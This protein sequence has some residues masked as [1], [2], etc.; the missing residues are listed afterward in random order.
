MMLMVRVKST[1]TAHIQLLKND[2]QFASGVFDLVMKL[3]Y[4]A[5]TP[6]NGIV[7]T[8]VG[9]IHDCMHSCVFVRRAKVFDDLG[10]VADSKELMG[11]EE[12][13]VA[14]VREIRSE[15]TI[16]SAFPALVFASSAGL[17]CAVVAAVAGG[18]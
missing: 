4:H 10:D 1:I 3:S 15:K 16:R 9:L 11:V 12:L 5:I 14:V 2:G 18:A 7:G 6:F 8:S 17:V 13:A